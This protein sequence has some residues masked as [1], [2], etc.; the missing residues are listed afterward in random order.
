MP[1]LRPAGYMPERRQGLSG[2]RSGRAVLWAALA[3]V[4]VSILSFCAFPLI[5]LQNDSIDY[6]NFSRYLQGRVPAVS[7]FLP[8]GYPALLALVEKVS[9]PDVGPVLL[10][11]QH[12]LRLVPFAMFFMMARL[13]PASAA[14]GVGAWLWAIFPE[15]YLF[16]HY[17]MSES[18]GIALV[19]ASMSAVLWLGARPGPA[20]SMLA[21]AVIG[22]LALTRP[23]GG[24]L[25]LAASLP[26]LRGKAGRAFVNL[27]ALLGAFVLALL[28]WAI[29]NR[30]QSGTLMPVNSAGRHLFNRVVAEDGLVAPGDREMAWLNSLIGFGANARPT[31]WWNYAPRLAGRGISESESDSRFLGIALRALRAHPF[32]YA[33]RTVTGAVR[34][35]FWPFTA[36]PDASGYRR[37]ETE[38]CYPADAGAV[39]SWVSRRIPGLPEASSLQDRLGGE[40]RA[41]IAGSVFRVWV[42]AWRAVLGWWPAQYV[43]LLIGL[44][45]LLFNPDRWGRRPA[46]SGAGGG[47]KVVAVAVLTGL[48]AHAAFEMP[49][50][51]YGLPFLPLVLLA[52]SAGLMAVYRFFA[53]SMWN[54]GT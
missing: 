45:C 41:N 27:S 1:L 37:L 9:G 8:P 17:L 32:K 54:T 39:Q 48:L 25:L 28:P 19:S 52:W 12:V 20:R 35:A 24:I 42:F 21:G 18:L 23:A 50:P 43:F 11:I 10:G 44:V 30:L 3:S 13:W 53:E 31:Y 15:S 26:L 7:L 49:V 29:H 38:L 4:A 51:R 46:G 6:W 33:F 16:A 47:E 40:W 2:S 36:P 34:I 22:A 5:P 14:P